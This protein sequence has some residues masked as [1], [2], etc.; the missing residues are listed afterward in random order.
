MVSGF[1]NHH[2]HANCSLKKGSLGSLSLPG[3]L[4][5]SSGYSQLSIPHCHISLFI[6]LTLRT[7]LLTFQYL[8]L[9]PL[10]F[11]HLPPISLPGP[12]LPLPPM[13]ILF[14]LLCRIEAFTLCSSF[15]LSFI[16]S[17]NCI[18]GIKNFWANIHLL[19][20]PY[21]VCSFVPGLSHSG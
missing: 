21:H 4:G 7:S 17:V 2:F 14:P 19:V 9:S 5:L 16:W 1:E 20:N 11:F 6:F 8:I 3:F 13:I 18:L 15:F 12:S 10:P